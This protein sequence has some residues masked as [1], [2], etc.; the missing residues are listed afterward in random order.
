MV[1][2][3][4]ETNGFRY[5]SGVPDAQSLF[6]GSCVAEEGPLGLDAIS[7]PSSLYP[8][9]DLTKPLRAS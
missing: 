7:V 3:K 9:E 6:A 2:G 5:R 1:R 4:G 8:E